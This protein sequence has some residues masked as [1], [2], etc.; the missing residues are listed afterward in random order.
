MDR[1]FS[2]RVT[3]QNSD[4]LANQ[5][6][7]RIRSAIL[8]GELPPGTRLTQQELVKWYGSSRMPVRQAL[9]QLKVEQLVVT[10]GPRTL[11]VAPVSRRRL[12]EAF[13]VRIALEPFAIRM[14]TEYV[15]AE[16]LTQ[17]HMA[18]TQ[19]AERTRD[20]LSDS[21]INDLLQ[22][23]QEFHS[24]I[25]SAVPNEYL[26]QMI[27]QARRETRRFSASF[28]P[29]LY[30][31]PGRAARELGEHRG[32]LRTI[33]ERDGESAARLL[34]RHLARSAED[35]LELLPN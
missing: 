18:L 15:T 21:D 26:R 4:N 22:A 5:I 12:E 9:E 25:D 7:H 24:V 6:A 14:A 35:L 32:I 20:N 28:L 8:T 31:R 1:L 30:Q 33:E 11:V 2:K 17:L 27:D 23:N 10:V 16:L 19:I 3:V 29:V 34:A 13:Q